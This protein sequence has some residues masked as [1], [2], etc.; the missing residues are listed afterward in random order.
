[1][2]TLLLA[3]V[4]AAAAAAEPEI[5]VTASRFP[6]TEAESAA[7][8][9]VIDDDTI[10]RLGEPLVPALVR[11][12]PSAA[13]E[14]GGPAGTLAQVR[15]RGAEANHTLLFIDG[16]RANDP[17]AGDIPRFELLNADIVSRVEI[18]RGPQSALWGSDAIGGV[19]AVNG[20]DAT[21]PG[22][23]TSAEAGSFGFRRAAA[24]GTVATRDA[25]L[26]GAIGWQR[27]RGIDSFDGTGD[28]D[29]YRNLSGRLRG[30]FAV[31]DRIEIGAAGFA[32]AGRSEF[33]GYDPVTFLRGDTL[34]STR[35][36]LAAGRVWI[37]AGDAEG[38]GGTLAT[39]LLH[40]SNRNFL[41]D[42][43][44]N[45]TS[46]KRWTAEAQAHYG[47]STGTVRHMAVIAL[48]H[49]R[50]RFRAS[51][52]VYFGATDQRRSRTHGSITAE[53][54]AEVSPVVA[55]IAVRHDRFSAFKDATTVRASAL[56]QLGR[57]ISV[58]GAYAEGIAQPTF[59]DLYGFFPGNFVG[60][61]SLKPES[62]RGFELS[63]RYRNGP[64]Q[65][66]LTGYRQRL[67]D[68]I[69]DVFDSATFTSST[70]N[71]ADVSRRS[72]LEAEA[73]WS[74]DERLRLTANYSY[75]RATQPAESL[76]G[77]LR[78]VRR[79]K[80]SAAIA[81]D[82]VIGRITYGGSIAYVGRR[83]DTNFDVFPAQ[84]VKL[85][86]YWLA[87][88]RIAYRVAPAIDLFARASNLF[89]ERYQDVFGYRTEGR[90]LFVGVE[91]GKK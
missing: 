68:E 74:A 84:P 90:G 47:F 86:A 24:S 50:E 11:L 10:D 40:S 2:L 83:G 80:H 82:G 51:D 34:D 46:G 7:S 61:P 1:M 87:G 9:T 36:R 63:L 23:A 54:R 76:V 59:F 71:R 14:T 35:N 31:G 32:L 78:E 77:Q 49:D 48:D 42:A 55:D 16:I 64:I 25:N 58:S 13:V 62:S 28:R 69:V 44:I 4:A 15:I 75:L 8:V 39:S 70:E 52:S 79:P 30:T 53:W 81:A 56:V 19:V 37:T 57:G 41:D 29:G 65:A 89:D 67:S 5:I 33:D 21:A 26:S 20:V 73:S 91:L 6:E 60:N 88:A 12:T 85:G 66:A 3:P 38:L 45:R 72:G 22:Y 27:A 17:A 18:V 43:E